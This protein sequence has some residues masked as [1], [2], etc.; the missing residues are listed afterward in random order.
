MI[1]QVVGWIL[2]GLLV[3]SVTVMLVSLLMYL[4]NECIEA[5]CGWY[6]KRLAKKGHRSLKDMSLQEWKLL[7]RSL[8]R[9]TVFV[10]D[11]NAHDLGN[12]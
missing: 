8:R 10:E 4:V 1:K 5:L 2:Q 7:E 3:V 6:K 12:V 11:D 9:K